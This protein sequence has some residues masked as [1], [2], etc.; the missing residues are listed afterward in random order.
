[1]HLVYVVATPRLKKSYTRTYVENISVDRLCVSQIIEVASLRFTSLQLG[2][3]LYVMKLNDRHG[4]PFLHQIKQ[5][6]D[7]YTHCIEITL[8]H[9]RQN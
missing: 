8:V 4:S 2:L 9:F 5:T 1:V 3:G 7:G 6:Y